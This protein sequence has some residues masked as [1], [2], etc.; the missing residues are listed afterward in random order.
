MNKICLI[1]LLLFGVLSSWS[2]TFTFQFTLDNGNNTLRLDITS[3]QDFTFNQLSSMSLTMSSGFNNISGVSSSQYGLV[4]DSDFGNTLIRL[5]GIVNGSDTW[6]ANNPV[7]VAEFDLIAG[8]YTAGNF[9]ITNS[10][11]PPVLPNFTADGIGYSV[12]P[13]PTDAILPIILSSFTVEKLNKRTAFLNWTSSQEINSSHFLVQR[14]DDG[15]NFFDIGRKEAAGNSSTPL[16]Y[17]YLDRNINIQRNASKLLYYRLK[18]V[19]IDGYTEFSEIKAVRFDR[20]GLADISVYPN[21]TSDILLLDISEDLE[22][23]LL[24]YEIY[25]VQGGLVA[26]QKIDIKNQKL[27]LLPLRNLG[28]QSGVYFIKLRSQKELLS[29]QKFVLI[30]Q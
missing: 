11:P 4:T 6:F 22:E 5:N 8:N 2:Q 9:V 10:G 24:N 29:S 12:T 28:L 25:N 23:N 1:L 20:I 19:D 21:P 7:T 13:L 16:H 15:S 26:N 14:S 3:S 17:D 18:Q 30:S 27:H